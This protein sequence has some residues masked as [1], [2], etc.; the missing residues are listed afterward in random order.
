VVGESSGGRREA[1]SIPHDPGEPSWRTVGESK[2]EAD[3][4][5]FA[6]LF[7]LPVGRKRWVDETREEAVIRRFVFC[8]GRRGC[9]TIR[10][11]IVR[12]SRYAWK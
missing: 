6:L 5:V 10:R 8:F 11:Y 3:E 2:S 1:A 4:R 7:V 12:K 9:C